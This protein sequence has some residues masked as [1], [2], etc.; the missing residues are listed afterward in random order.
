MVSGDLFIFTALSGIGVDIQVLWENSKSVSPPHHLNFMNPK[1]LNLLLIR[2]GFEN[3]EVTTPGKLDLDI[4][5]NNGS[6]I[7]D[8]FWCTFIRVATDQEKKVWQEMIA[9]SGLSSHMMAVC[10]KP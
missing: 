4:L 2:L 10:R 5:A 3:L 8:R 6:F 1:S 7:K 9:S